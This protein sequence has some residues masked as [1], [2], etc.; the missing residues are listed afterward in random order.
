MMVARAK[1]IAPDSTRSQN[2]TNLLFLTVFS[3]LGNK[4]SLEKDLD[5]PHAMV[6][7]VKEECCLAPENGRSK[8]LVTAKH[9]EFDCFAFSA[10][11]AMHPCPATTR[12]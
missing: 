12:L 9:D 3:F 11:P 2:C 10:A 8:R 1:R 7:L 5:K 4:I 6:F